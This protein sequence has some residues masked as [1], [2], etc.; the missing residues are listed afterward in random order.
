MPVSRAALTSVLQSSLAPGAA[1]E[2]RTNTHPLTPGLGG[3]QG[4][5]GASGRGKVGDREG[6]PACAQVQGSGPPCDLG[7]TVQGT[8][9]DI[10]RRW[11]FRPL[12]RVGWRGGEGAACDSSGCAFSRAVEV[13]PP[14][15]K[16]GDHTPPQP[17]ACS[18]Q[19]N[20]L[21]MW[22]WRQTPVAERLS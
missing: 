8:W 6:R 12:K 2:Q 10:S 22:T 14:H 7:L 13:R 15:R 3:P 5:C 18:S 11:S 1:Q 4:T 19:R 16:G 17:P 9:A 20:P 21:E